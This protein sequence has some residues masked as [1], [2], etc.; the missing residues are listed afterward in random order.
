M[1]F[2]A[3]GKQVLK[4]GAHYADA[5]TDAAAIAIA[6]ALNLPAELDARASRANRVG[7]RSAA[8]IYRI[9]ADDI[10]AG[11]MEG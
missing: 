8:R 6:S 2:R 9:L 7:N 1:T 11:V 3:S 10:R 4:D 5:R